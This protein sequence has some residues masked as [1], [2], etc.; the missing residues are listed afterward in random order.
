[1]KGFLHWGNHPYREMYFFHKVKEVSSGSLPKHLSFIMWA[2]KNSIPHVPHT[3]TRTSVIENLS[4]ATAIW[5]A[6]IKKTP[7]RWHSP[8]T[9]HFPP[10]FICFGINGAYLYFSVTKDAATLQQQQSKLS[11]GAYRSKRWVRSNT[12]PIPFSCPEALRGICPSSVSCVQTQM[13]KVLQSGTT[14]D[15]EME[16]GM[17]ARLAAAGWC[18]ICISGEPAMI[19]KSFGCPLFPLYGP[20]RSCTMMCCNP[21]DLQI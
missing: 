3:I 11:K 1:M 4:A 13:P 10:R 19:E 20:L 8:G 18:A 5:P 2:G 7:C 12:K 14:R 9:S 17:L 15:G 16:Q 21:D 6:N